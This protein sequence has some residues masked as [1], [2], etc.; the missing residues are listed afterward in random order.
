MKF[1]FD[2]HRLDPLFVAMRAHKRHML[3]GTNNGK[4]RKLLKFYFGGPD[5]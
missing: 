5:P 1:H 2:S 3:S 4:Y